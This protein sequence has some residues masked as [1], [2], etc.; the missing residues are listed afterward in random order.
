MDDIERE[1]EGEEREKMTIDRNLNSSNKK[2]KK[3]ILIILIGI[4]IILGVILTIYFVGKDKKESNNKSNDNI[5]NKDEENKSESEDEEIKTISYVSCDDNTSLLNVRSSV[6][7]DIID[8]LSC[9]K[10][11]TIE[12]ELEATE[13]CAKWY[14][15]S[16]QKRGKSY[17]GYSCGTYIKKNEINNKTIITVQNLIDKA[18]E[19]RENSLLK[20]YCG[21]TTGSKEIELSSGSDKMTGEYLKS[22]YKTIDDLK[23]YL[24][25]FMDESL[26]ELKLELS[27]INNPKYYDN[28][29]EIDGN[30]YCRN[31]SNK[32]YNTLYTGNYDFEITSVTDNKINVTISYEYLTEDASNNSECKNV[33][34]LSEC[35]NSKFT[36]SLGK[37]VIEK[38]E[39]NYIITK[40]DFYK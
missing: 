21:K 15:I 22:E 38:K 27:D 28:Y 17:T 39:D 3:V 34:D 18:L 7:G 4:I 2:N 5:V 8:G 40:I 30:L 6:S 24:L 11:V 19:Y 14:R 12:E 1:I 37:I 25:S 26:I 31:Y 23:E 35:P 36:Y 13:N 29:Y 9:F 16:Y 20:A 32:G 10:E 33:E